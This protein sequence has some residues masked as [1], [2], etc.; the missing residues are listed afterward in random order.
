MDDNPLVRARG[1][2]PRRRE[3]VELSKRK[4]RT[5]AKKGVG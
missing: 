3:R 2:I 1:R 4:V 5:R